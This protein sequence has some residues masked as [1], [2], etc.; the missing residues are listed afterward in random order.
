MWPVSPREPQRGR[1]YC[2]LVSHQLNK[3]RTHQH[4]AGCLCTA[5]EKHHQD[6]SDCNLLHI[7]WTSSFAQVRSASVDVQQADSS[8]S[9]VYM[10]FIDY[11]RKRE[12]FT[13]VQSADECL[14]KK[15]VAEWQGDKICRTCGRPSER[16]ESSKQTQRQISLWMSS[17]FLFILQRTDGLH[18][19]KQMSETL[20]NARDHVQH[21][22]KLHSYLH[23]EP[24]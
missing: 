20:T 7:V 19:L 14:S 21:D 9:L 3:E 12:V 10:I 22:V 15:V 24:Y 4:A 18:G 5:C 16:G 1:Q 13:R 11:C 17:L 2:S 6:N 8:L 23:L